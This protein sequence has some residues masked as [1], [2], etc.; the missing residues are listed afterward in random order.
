MVRS[1]LLIVCALAAALVACGQMRSGNPQDVATKVTQALY[2]N[3][4]GGVTQNFDDT[5]KAKATR[6]QVAAISDKMHTLGDFK[7]LSETKRDE[8]TRRYWYDAKF[9]NG[10]M[11]VEMRLHSDG[12][13]AAYR[14]VPA[15]TTAP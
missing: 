10:D 3:D 12:S 11:T 2:N 7:G 13:I 15:T 4:L 5:L 6:I 8:D 9:S 14:V 1:R